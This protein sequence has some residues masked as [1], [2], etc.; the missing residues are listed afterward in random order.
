[1]KEVAHNA[2]TEIHVVYLIPHCRPLTRIGIFI[3]IR[4]LYV[5][6][7]TCASQLVLISIINALIL[8]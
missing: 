2:C 8:L 7:E 3:Q 6:G 1:M 4:I 5:V